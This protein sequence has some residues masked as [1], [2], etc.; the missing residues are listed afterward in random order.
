[1]NAILQRIGQHRIAGIVLV[2]VLLNSV[3]WVLALTLFPTDTPAAILHYSVGAGVDFIGE[4]QRIVSLPIVGTVVILLNCAL[5][6]G[7]RDT[8]KRFVW[9]FL[10]IMPLIQIVLL[11]AF[12]LLLRVNS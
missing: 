12:A 11:T 7:M 5:A 10:S 1:M 8:S 4:G 2:S 9:L 6:Y 3:L